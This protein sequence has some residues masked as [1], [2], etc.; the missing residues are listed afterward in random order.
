MK[1]IICVLVALTFLF[2]SFTP[3][4]VLAANTKK[5]KALHAD[6]YSFKVKSED[7]GDYNLLNYYTHEYNDGDSFTHSPL[8]YFIESD[9]TFTLVYAEKD[10]VRLIRLKGSNLKKKDELKLAKHLKYVVGATIDEDGNYYVAFDEPQGEYTFGVA[11]YDH[12]GKE[13]GTYMYKITDNPD[14]PYHGSHATLGVTGGNF[15]MCA[16]DGELVCYFGQALNSYAEG[17][18][19]PYQTSGVYA[20]K[21]ADMSRI[22]DYYTFSSISCDQ[23]VIKTSEGKWLFADLNTGTPGFMLEYSGEKRYEPFHVKN[24][25]GYWTSAGIGNVLELP[26]GFA[27]VGYAPRDTVEGKDSELFIQI[28]DKYLSYNVSKG[29]VRMTVNG[30]NRYGDNGIIWLTKDSEKRI[31]GCNAALTDDGNIVIT[32]SRQISTNNERLVYVTVVT[33]EGEVILKETEIGYKLNANEDIVYYNGCVYWAT[34]DRENNK[35]PVITV[36]KLNVENPESFSFSYKYEHKYTGKQVKPKLTVK[37]KGEKL[38]EGTDYTL[39]Y[40]NNTYVSYSNEYYET[41]ARMIVKGKGKYAGLNR[42]FRFK[43]NK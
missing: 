38:K 15:A 13:V 28:I 20:F 29:E 22:Y 32:Y 41:F 2:T 6:T 8:S 34:G 3:T 25:R 7:S 17:S 12:N 16:K 42:A 37:F 18:S 36:Y 35:K 31:C 33:P 26:Q 30:D 10:Y 23:R 1:K 4:S 5:A 14:D 11:K 40:Q 27:L 19:W 21:T 39:T 9:G 43:I 24:L